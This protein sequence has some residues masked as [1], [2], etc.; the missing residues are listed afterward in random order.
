MVLNDTLANV[1]SQINNAVR[2]EKAS[3][4]T[5]VAAKLIKK[6]LAIMQEN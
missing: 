4:K 2:V 6:V 5:N 3:V 1:L